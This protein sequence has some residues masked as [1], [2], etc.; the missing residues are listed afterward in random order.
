MKGK[1]ELEKLLEGQSEIG[2]ESDLAL[3]LLSDGG[4]NEDFDSSELV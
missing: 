4:V 1:L 3:G 2:A